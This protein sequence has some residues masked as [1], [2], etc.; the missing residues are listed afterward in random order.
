VIVRENKFCTEL[1]VTARV[2]VRRWTVAR[3]TVEFITLENV[4][5]CQDFCCCLHGLLS[6]IATVRN[7]VTGFPHK[8]VKIREVTRVILSRKCCISICPI[9]NLYIAE[10]LVMNVYGCNRKLYSTFAFH[11]VQM[12]R[13]PCVR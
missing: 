1:N 6:L 2:A 10:I 5:V 12:K 8:C 13:T 7:I 3:M 4:C 9:S 11:T